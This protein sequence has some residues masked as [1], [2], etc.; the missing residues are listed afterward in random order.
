MSRDGPSGGRLD[1]ARFMDTRAGAA[2]PEH[3]EA[4]VFLGAITEAE[5]TQVVERCERRLFAAGEVVVDVGDVDRSLL[6]LVAGS[7]GVFLDS[8]ADEPFEVIGSPSVV[9][10]LAFLDG[11]PRSAT[12]RGIEAGEVLRLR[13]ED[14]EALAAEVPH[15][16]QA[17]LLDLGRILA[18]RLRRWSPP[19]QRG[20]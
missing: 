3:A 8:R 16:G 11:L 9:G 13:F 17:I 15:I 6:I 12:L 19:A 10:E 4:V 2:S 14:F 20:R 5:W 7:I 1:L 18:M